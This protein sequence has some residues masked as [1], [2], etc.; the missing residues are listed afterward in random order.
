MTPENRNS[1][2]LENGSLT[3]F[4][5][6]CGFVET[7]LVR[8]TLFMSTESTNNFHGFVQATNVFHGYALGYIRSCAEK[9][10]SFV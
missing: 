8:N 3:H 6:G 5:W 4:L 7:D 1:S 10:E 2:L 9:K